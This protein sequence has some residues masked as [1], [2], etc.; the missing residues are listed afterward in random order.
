MGEQSVQIVDGKVERWWKRKDGSARY[1]T[2]CCDCGLTHDELIQS[3][4][5]YYA[6]TVWRDEKRTKANRGKRLVIGIKR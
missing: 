5:R 3:R 4:G 2:I 6:I 1:H